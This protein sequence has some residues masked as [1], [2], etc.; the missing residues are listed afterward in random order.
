MRELLNALAAE[1]TKLRGTL[2][3][4]MCW[5]APFVVVALYVMLKIVQ[6]DPAQTPSPDQAWAGFASECIGLW[7]FLMLPLFVTLQ[8]A[9]LAGLEHADQ[10][11]KHLLA[12]P[13]PRAVHYIAKLVA[14]L[15]MTL[16]A[17]V[18]LVLFLEV[19]G[20]ILA[21]LKPAVGIRGAA[22][23]ADLLATCGR[24]LAASTLIVALHTWIAIRWPSFT[25]A[26]ATGMTATVISF[27]V[28]QSAEYGRY[29]PWSM[30]VRVLREGGADNT[31][32]LVAALVGS[33]AVALAGLWD[34][35]RRDI[36]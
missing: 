27:L 36:A 6:K 1:R 25:I 3:S 8:S 28:A 18:A 14:L 33:V 34:F 2:A 22:P 9:L 15:A 19:G 24:V 29:Y 30:P 35:N 16:A 5:L 20:H 21:W 17:M 10:Q 12:L 23:H 31:F 13:V 11:W 4:R 26:V 7:T 32:V